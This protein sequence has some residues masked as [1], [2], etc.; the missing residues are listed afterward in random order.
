[1]NWLVI[2]LWEWSVREAFLYVLIGLQSNVRVLI[3][4]LLC[5]LY[6]V[7]MKIQNTDEI[8][9]LLLGKSLDSRNEELEKHVFA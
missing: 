9:M 1:M 8:G 3:G 5:I 7:I 4:I 6:F 2:R